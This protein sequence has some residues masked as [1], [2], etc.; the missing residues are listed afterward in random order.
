MTMTVLEALDALPKTPGEIAVFLRNRSYFGRRG[1]ACDCPIALYLVAATGD[2]LVAVEPHRVC[3][4]GG[5][6]ALPP[7]VVDFV[8][9]FDG[10]RWPNLIKAAPVR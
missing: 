9:L 10:A 5:S 8:E 7:H 6:T 2:Q 4:T 1:N 3:F